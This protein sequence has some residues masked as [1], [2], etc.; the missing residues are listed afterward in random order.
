MP[1]SPGVRGGIGGFGRTPA[2]GGVTMIPS[3][4]SLAG[5]LGA[6]L[7]AGDEAEAK[8]EASTKARPRYP[9]RQVQDRRTE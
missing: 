1:H 9:V 5:L 2:G 8:E 6:D 7:G 3:L 4:P